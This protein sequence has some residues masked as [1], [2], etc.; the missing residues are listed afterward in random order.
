MAHGCVFFFLFFLPLF[1]PVPLLLLL[2]LL[3]SVLSLLLLLF[4]AHITPL[5]AHVVYFIK[6][7][8]VREYSEFTKDKRRVS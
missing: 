3:V 2:L 7:L 8:N 1:L 5:E 6:D 4:C